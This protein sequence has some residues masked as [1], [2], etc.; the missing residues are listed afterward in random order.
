MNCK[1]TIEANNMFILMNKNH[2]M[3][4][5]FVR[6][7][8]NILISKKYLNEFNIY[9]IAIYKLVQILVICEAAGEN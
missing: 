2:C 3:N 8:F 1:V 6:I 4:T 5:F 7:C 9:I